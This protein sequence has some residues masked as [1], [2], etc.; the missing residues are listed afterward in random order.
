MFLPDFIDVEIDGN[1]VIV[2]SDNENI[3]WK[4]SDDVPRITTMNLLSRMVAII[5]YLLSDISHTNIYYSWNMI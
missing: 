2:S 1:N 4:D 5:V 3:T